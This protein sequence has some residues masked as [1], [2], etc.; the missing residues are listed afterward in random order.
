MENS[1]VFRINVQSGEIELQGSEE[2]VERQ[3]QHLQDIL[4]LV[5]EF[6]DEQ[7]DENGSIPATALVEDISASATMDNDVPESFL[8]WFYEFP[9]GVSEQDKALITGY[10]LQH[11]STENRFL[12]SQVPKLLRENGIPIKN[13]NIHLQRL[14]KKRLVIPVGRRGKSTFYRVTQEGQEYLRKIRA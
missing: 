3:I 6:V 1:A 14:A 12:S 8:E 2:F 13:S 5:A 10:F 4:D 9:K 7:Q 11:N